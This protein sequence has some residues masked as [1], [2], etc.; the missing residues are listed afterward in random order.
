MS[1]C[2]AC[3][4]ATA[5]AWSFCAQCGARVRPDAGPPRIH[6]DDVLYNC[7]TCGKEARYGELPRC[8]VCKD[9]CCTD[10][11][12]RCTECEHLACR[13]DIIE[14]YSCKRI[15]C[16]ACFDHCETCEVRGLC[17]EHNVPCED[18]GYPTCGECMGGC[19]KCGLEVCTFCRDAH[20]AEQR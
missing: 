7:Q 3:G 20:K 10:C 11:V 19:R 4:S 5:E 8:S 15:G 18:C 17:P 14:C 1:A 9:S 12:Q 2:P 6:L 13:A 16:A